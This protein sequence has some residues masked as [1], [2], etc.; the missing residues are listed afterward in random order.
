VKNTGIGVSGRVRKI[1][2]VT[3][4]GSLVNI[5]LS[6][7]KIAAGIVG[8]S[9]AMIADGVHSL[10]DLLTD[11]I[12]I[13]FVGISEK[14]RDGNH[15]YGHGKYE[16]FATMLVS[17]ILFLVGTGIFWSG[18]KKVIDS[19]NGVS[20]EQ[21]GLIALYAALV[22]IVSKEAL[23]WYTRISGRQINSQV[24]VANAWHHRS[25]AFTS[26]GTALGIS[27]AIFL[28]EK[29]RILDPVA[30]IIVSLFILKIAWKIANPSVKELLE[31]SLP[32]ETEN[33][34]SEIIANTAGVKCF[35]NLRTRKIGEAIAIDVH[36]KVD[37]DL[38][39]ESSHNIASE[40]ENSLREKFGSQSHIGIHI[41]PFYGHPET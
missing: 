22:S 41:E 2:E 18:A 38:S 21:P 19:L 14:E 12:V 30:G 27:G 40:I 25:D 15:R 24:L 20:I 35:H 8:K 7:G 3:I 32:A 23:F 36:V 4:I 9:S 31:S 37:K 5:L 10:S 11:I 33:D 29:W 26:F 28:G 13:A 39:V 1:R 34:I 16:T 6:A 17:F